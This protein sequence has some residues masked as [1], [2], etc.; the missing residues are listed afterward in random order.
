LSSAA[1]AALANPFIA[2]APKPAAPAEMRNS[3]RLGMH[4][5]ALSKEKAL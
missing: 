2:I 5:I 1:K 4:M 3:R